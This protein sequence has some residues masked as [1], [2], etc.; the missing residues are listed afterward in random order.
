MLSLKMHQAFLCCSIDNASVLEQRCPT[1]FFCSPKMWQ[2]KLVI[3]HIIV[4]TSIFTHSIKLS[5]PILLSKHKIIQP[6][7]QKVQKN[8]FFGKSS[9]R[10]I[11]PVIHHMWRVANWLDNTV[12]ECLMLVDQ[13]DKTYKP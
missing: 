4:C 10:H 8:S 7:C 6:S 2:I 5:E 13:G 3:C 12:L 9:I 1:V 11:Q